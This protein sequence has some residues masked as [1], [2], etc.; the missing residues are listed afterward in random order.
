MQCQINWNKCVDSD[1]AVD[2]GD[3]NDDVAISGD[4]DDGNVTISDD[5]NDVVVT[6]IHGMMVMIMIVFYLDCDGGYDD[7]ID[8]DKDNEVDVSYYDVGNHNDDD[9]DDNDD[10]L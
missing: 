2:D 10:A 9:N 7:T 8:D 5:G 4:S 3:G 1:I 6:M